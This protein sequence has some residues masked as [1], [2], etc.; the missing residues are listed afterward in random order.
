M[1]SLLTTLVL[2]AAASPALA[3]D[4]VVPEPGGIGAVAGAIGALIVLKALR[5]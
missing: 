2:L 4:V 3:G 1:K 5:K